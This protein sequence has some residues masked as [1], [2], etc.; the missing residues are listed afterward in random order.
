MAKQ[1]ETE[2]PKQ[3]TYQ[4]PEKGKH[5]LYGTYDDVQFIIGSALRYGLGRQSYAV[6]LIAD[7]IGE[8]LS[9]LNEKWMVNLLRDV[10]DYEK[11][12][13]NG[14]I[15]DADY[16]LESWLKLKA[17]LRNEFKSRNFE[18]DLRYYGLE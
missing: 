10:Q 1:K 16:D 15:H 3:Y 13:E 11:D 9:L 4:T 5:E 18:R 12:R 6:G 2:H 7:F 8:N 17:A 14:L